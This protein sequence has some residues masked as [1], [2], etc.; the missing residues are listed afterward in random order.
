LMGRWC[1]RRA[2]FDIWGQ[3]CKRMGTSIKMW[4]IKSKLDGWSSEKPLA[5]SVTRVPQKLKGK[6]YRT[7]IRPTLLYGAECWPTKKRHV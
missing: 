5:Y 4:K 6:F 1:S 7:M 2:P 3:W